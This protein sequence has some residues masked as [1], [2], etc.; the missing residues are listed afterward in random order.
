MERRTSNFNVAQ[1]VSEHPWLQLQ[2]LHKSTLQRQSYHYG[3]GVCQRD[4]ETGLLSSS[5]YTDS[6]G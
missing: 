5:C 3:P 2:R 6:A 4:L 1:F